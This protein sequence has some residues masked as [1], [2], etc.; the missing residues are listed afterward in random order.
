MIKKGSGAP[1]RGGSDRGP[2]ET[3]SRE[4]VCSAMRGH[5]EQLIGYAAFY[6]SQPIP[7]RLGLSGGRTDLPRPMPGGR[8]A[9][10]PKLPASLADAF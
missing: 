6:A 2:N 9:L 5:E 7:T 4:T 1:K 8:T 3:D 10:H